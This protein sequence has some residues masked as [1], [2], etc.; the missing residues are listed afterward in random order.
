MNKKNY[1]KALAGCLRLILHIL[2]LW[3][4]FSTGNLV[5]SLAGCLGVCLPYIKT[6][7]IEKELSFR[8][9]PN[10]SLR[11][12]FEFWKSLTFLC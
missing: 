7:K 8:K 11:K 5:L 1:S 3:I 2:P 12:N 9:A 10:E 6:K 4:F